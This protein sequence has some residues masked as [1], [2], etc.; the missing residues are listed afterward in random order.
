MQT[1]QNEMQQLIID[2]FEKHDYDTMRECLKIY[3]S[4]LGTDSFFEAYTIKLLSSNGPKVSL[5]CLDVDDDTL[6]RYLKT[7][8]YQNL[9][10]VR[11][12]G[13]D[14]IHDF[15]SY[16][17][18]CD[19]KYLCFL[20]KHQHYIPSRIASMIYYQETTTGLDAV[21]CTRNHID[22]NGN[23]IAHPDYAYEETLADKFLQGKLLLEYSI[24]ANVN[25][26][27]I[28]STVIV[29][30]AYAKTLSFSDTEVTPDLC[31]MALLYQLLLH[32]HIFYFYTP[33]VSTYLQDYE[34]T[35]ETQE[36]YNSY[37]RFLSD[38]GKLSC[39]VPNSSQAILRRTKLPR[40]ITFINNK[41]GGGL[42]N[43]QPLIEEAKRRGFHVHLTDNRY[44]KAEIA[45]YSQHICFPENAKFSVILLHDLMQGNLSWPNFWEVERWH[46]FDLGILPGESWAERFKM[47][48]CFYYAN[49]RYGVYT[50]GYPK[51]D[52]ITPDF[53]SQR[54]DEMRKRLS[55]KHPFTV[56]YAPSWENDGKEDDFIQALSSLKINLLI[57]Q[58]CW[59]G[60]E[61]ILQ[62]IHDM[63]KLHENKFDNV[64]F[65]S[66]EESIINAISACDLLVS[67]E[68]NVMADAILLNKPSIA[69]T[70]W[71]IPDKTPSRPAHVPIDYVIKCTKDKLRQT[72][73]DVMMH[74]IP[75]EEYIERGWRN[76]SNAGN[77]C[78]EIMDAIEYFTQDVPADFQSDFLA[79][80]VVDSQYTI[81]SMWN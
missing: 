76:F 29:S 7:E 14:Y 53:L 1:P 58:N 45:V 5:I 32:A 56:L 33:C 13:N 37:I 26:Y 75:V 24:N 34:D 20:E 22:E 43:V 81:C 44:E 64:Y 57:K 30:S 41:Y 16:L 35:S 60:H 15:V 48:N 38:T 65:I 3:Q 39:T 46:H 47:C 6:N 28:L 61:N 59:K 80:Q 23:V 78:R 79:K 54:E 66:E 77:C 74:K 17:S 12:I 50:L 10:I 42:Y 70:D 31:S 51:S 40:D 9:E 55:L 2:C 73:L 52:Q 11:F 21:I 62:N 68:S 8:D 27:G 49:P 19:N 72:V 67:D 69:V 4:S 36:H 63:R 18:S 25:L 71:M